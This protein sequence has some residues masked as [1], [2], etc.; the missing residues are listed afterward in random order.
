MQ[1]NFTNLVAHDA[2]RLVFTFYKIDAYFSLISKK[3]KVGIQENHLKLFL[4]V[5]KIQPMNKNIS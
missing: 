5:S 4:T 1:K 3:I 2:I